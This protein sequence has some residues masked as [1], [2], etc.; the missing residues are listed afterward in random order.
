MIPRDE[1]ARLHKSAREVHDVLGQLIVP[2]GG[3]TYRPDWV[4]WNL[5]HIHRQSTTN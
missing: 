3:E 5:H 2:I 1:L 4:I